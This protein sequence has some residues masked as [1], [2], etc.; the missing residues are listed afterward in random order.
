MTVPQQTDNNPDPDPTRHARVVEDKDAEAKGSDAPL[1]HSHV[2]VVV[3]ATSA[4]PPNRQRPGFLGMLVG[5]SLVLSLTALALSLSIIYSLSNA[6]RTAVEGLERAINALEHLE[7]EGLHYE[8]RLQRAFPVSSSIP[9]QEEIVIP[10]KE[11]FP[12]DTVVQVPLDAGVLGRFMID[13]PIETS[14]ELDTEVPIR[15]DQTFE[16][17][18]TI[19]LSMVI[20][21]DVRPDDPVVQGGIADLRSWLVELRDSLDTG[22]R[23][24][25]PGN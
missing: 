3:D 15:I 5:V 4:R 16:I 12:I 9:V 21:I 17:S 11:D 2:P 14:V 1:P 20:P 8:Y 18:T 22:L 23:F 6:Q 10:L 7:G 25:L 13:V 19:P 24:P